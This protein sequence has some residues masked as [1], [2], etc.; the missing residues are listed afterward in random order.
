MQRIGRVFTKLMAVAIISG[1]GWAV[2]HDSITSKVVTVCDMSQKP[3]VAVMIQQTQTHDQR[4]S[5]NLESC[6]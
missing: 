5:T 6:R 1:G 2:A 3:P 4:Y